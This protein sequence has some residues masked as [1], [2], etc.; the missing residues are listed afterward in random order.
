MMYKVIA[1]F[2]DLQDKNFA[3]GVGDKFPRAGY[4]PSKKRIAELASD[5][6]RQGKPLI[7]EVKPKAEMEKND[8]DGDLSG[9]QKLV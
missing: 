4:H 1:R 3:Y 7:K 2:T 5:K 9:N 8:V 6:N